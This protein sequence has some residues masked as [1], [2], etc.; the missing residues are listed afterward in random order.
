MPGAL[1]SFIVRLFLIE[2][3]FQGAAGS[4]VGAM[5]GLLLAFGRALFFYRATDPNTGRTCWLAV[6]YFPGWQ[7]LLLVLVGVLVGVIL[8]VI[9]AIYPAYRAAKMEPVEA[10]RSEA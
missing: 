7:V 2:S 8:S 9:A 6:R 4:L 10:M 5:L 3:S 1:D